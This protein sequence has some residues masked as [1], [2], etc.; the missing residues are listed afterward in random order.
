M[1]EKSSPIKFIDQPLSSV[2]RIHPDQISHLK[3]LNLFTIGDI[4]RHFPTR[5]GGTSEAQYI[6]D[7]TVGQS[8]TVYGRIGKLKTGKSFRSHKAMAEGI[9]TD[10]TGSLKVVWLHQPYIAKL[11]QEGSLVKVTGKVTRRREYNGMMNP[12]I[13]S[14]GV[15]PDQIGNNLFAGSETPVEHFSPVYPETKG[16]TSKWIYH[17]LQ[18]IFKSP[19]FESI[20]DPIPAEI[21]KKYN[22]PVLKTSLI[23]IHNPQKESDAQV[24]R[25]RFAFEEVFY[26]QI[27]NQQVRAAAQKE[28]AYVIEP[29][30]KSLK[31]FTDRFPFG[32]TSSQ[33]KSVKD[34]LDDFK[35]GA[36]MS[37]LLEGDVG[38]G[39][40]AVAATTAY[41]VVTTRP[42]NKDKKV[43][44]F[45]NLQVAYMAPTEILAKQHFES[46]I[47]YFKHMPI[48]IGFISGTGCRKFPSKVNNGGTSGNNGWTDI[49][50]A[51][52][53]KWVKNG[54][55]AILI[56]T[57]ALIQKTVEFKDLAYVIIDEQHRFGTMQRQKLA[58]KHNVTPHLLSMTATPIPRTLAL[59]LYGDLD[60]S[61]IDQMPTGRKP[62]VTEIITEP[63]RESAYEKIRQ[64]LKEGRQVY[65]I[66]PR[67]EE[68]D[69]DKE[70]ALNVKSVIEEA[71]R[72]KEKVFKEW[73]IDILHSKMK[74]KEKDAVMLQ[75]EK[76]EID[77]LVATSVVEVGVNVPN[78]T[79][80]LIE[81]AERFG[82]SQLHQ[83]RGRVI[84]SNH[85]AYCFVFSDSKSEKTTERLKAINTA[86]NGFELSEID[87][88]LRGAGELY[89]GK[90]WGITD[91]GM[92][93]I[94]NI[95]MVEAARNEAQII[96][97]EDPSI[98]K[99]P[100][101]R[102][103]IDSK[104]E[105]HFE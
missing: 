34:I 91:I 93:A 99:Y 84:R 2:I 37:R 21:L 33:Q 28:K 68:A 45:G 38:S 60:L 22:L 56:G 61:L 40:T 54:E 47:T 90:Q 39:K 71:K 43:Q 36:P 46:F 41:G 76:K 70:Q 25:K 51:Q 79:I 19:L 8:S 12:E 64:E 83:L 42:K 48:S 15:L 44:D 29:S 35:K 89:G 24:A 101:L 31:E 23:W 4:L 67:I 52:L 5:Y 74:P 72:L 75:F 20:E 13:E 103:T 58:R 95:K 80:I 1:P 94:K 18:R 62:I 77:I 7:L 17:T 81:G 50:R 104:R 86:K 88:K 105:I 30:S 96:V 59:T 10:N 73:N 85:Q 66:C 3:K 102:Q 57:H 32:L 87:L 26:I 49:S 97:K 69:P 27:K 98:A 78:A 65:V 9:V 14:V 16:V 53:L 63:K 6:Q 92:E 100:I 11:I 55:L 82:L